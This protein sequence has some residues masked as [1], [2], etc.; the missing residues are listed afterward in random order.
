MTEKYKYIA[1][2]VF[3]GTVSRVVPHLANFTPEVLF[4]FIIGNTLNRNTALLATAI[5]AILS[6]AFIALQMHLSVFGHWTF[7]TYSA[8][9][10]IALLAPLFKGKHPRKLFFIGGL[11]TTVI[12]WLWTNFGTWIT[13]SLYPHTFSGLGTCYLFALPFLQHSLLA[14]LAWSFIILATSSRSF[15][16]CNKNTLLAS[17]TKH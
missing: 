16:F 9:G 17:I 3:I 8:L 4:A 15:N 5:M 2:L 13:T 6:D 1:L 10:G 11:S 12:F 14:T 7:F